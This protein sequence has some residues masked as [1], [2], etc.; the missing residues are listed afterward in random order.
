M[1]LIKLTGDAERATQTTLDTIEIT[2]KLAASWGTPPF[3]REVRLNCRVQAVSEQLKKDGVIPGILTLGVLDGK[4]FVVDG[5]HRLAAFQMSDLLVVYADVRMHYF[6]TMGEMANEFV[7]LNSALS[8]LR[9]DDILRGLEQS[10]KHLQ[11]IRQRCAFVGYDRI[12]SGTTTPVVSMATMIR[13]WNNSRSEVP[14]LQGSAQTLVT[15]M[16]NIETDRLCDFL[17]VCF[18][19][20]KR[21]AEYYNL[22]GTLNLMLCAWLYRRVV[23]GDAGKGTSR[24]TKLTVEEFRR[25]LLALSAAPDYMEYLVGRRICDRDRGPAYN[26]LKA[27]IAHRCWE[28]RKTKVQLPGP[29]WAHNNVANRR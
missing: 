27:I 29:P 17:A 13:V 26:R 4:V 16:D 2:K 20:W 8:R 18:A 25:G 6:R 10:D 5:L 11:V 19:A 3:Q 22:W 14:A 15:Q 24:S 12:R 7:Q 23:I 9:P 28:D 21:D 1:R